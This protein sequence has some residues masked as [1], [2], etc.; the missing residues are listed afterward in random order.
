M[1]KEISSIECEHRAK[2]Q[3]VSKAQKNVE[4]TYFKMIMKTTA[5]F[6]SRS[7]HII[8]EV[9]PFYCDKAP[10]ATNAI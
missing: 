9:N 3:N 7:D 10:T 1:N 8:H 2:E 5:H 4:K 6:S